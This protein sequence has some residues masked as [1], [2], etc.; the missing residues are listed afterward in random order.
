MTKIQPKTMYA[1]EYLD[2]LQLQ[3]Q[4]FAWKE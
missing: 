1:V 2:F 4:M 3:T